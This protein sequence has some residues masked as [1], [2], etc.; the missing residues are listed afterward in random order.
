MSLRLALPS[1]GALFEGAAQFMASCGLRVSRASSRRYT[2]TVPALPGVEVL[3]QRQSDITSE[4][5]GESADV[6]IVGLD[7]YRE[8]RGEGGDTLL[9]LDDL[10]F[11]AAS[12]VL[13]VPD[14]WV[15][16]T[17]VYDLADLALE[18]KNRGRELRVATKYPRLVKRFLN[19]RGINYFSLVHASGGLEA[20]PIMG[21]ADMIADISATGVTLRENRLRPL[22]DGT[23]IDSQA[24]LVGNGR[25]LAADPGRLALMRSILE[26]IESSIRARKYQRISA[27]IQGESAEDVARLVM[28]ERELAGIQGPTVSDVYS[29]DGR[30]W[31]NVQVVVGKGELISAVDHFRGMGGSG[32]TVNE[33]SYVFRARCDSYD[34]LMSNLRPY[35]EAGVPERGA[36]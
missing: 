35:Y 13:A 27:N 26:R 7:R 25:L 14:A 11:G 30:K 20:A 36:Q 22:L 34:R 32:I 6:G 9:I 3:F 23:V 17:N 33:A 10:G 29:D 21:Y 12:L 24:A 1:E 8:S 18:F 2:A 4:I 28:S 16:V 19:L 15:D 31:F 5:D